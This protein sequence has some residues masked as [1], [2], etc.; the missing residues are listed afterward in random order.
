M[1]AIYWIIVILMTT[2]L[3]ADVP[4]RIYDPWSQVEYMSKIDYR[5]HIN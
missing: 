5:R 3:I 2:L 4:V 1:K